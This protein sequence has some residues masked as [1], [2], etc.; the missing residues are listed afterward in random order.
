MVPLKIYTSKDS[1]MH[2]STVCSTINRNQW[3]TPAL[4]QVE[5]RWFICILY[6]H[7]S[8]HCTPWVISHVLWV[9]WIIWWFRKANPVIIPTWNQPIPDVGIIV[10]VKLVAAIIPSVRSFMSVKVLIKAGFPQSNLQE[11]DDSAITGFQ[12]AWSSQS[13]NMANDGNSHKDYSHTQQTR[14]GC[15]HGLVRVTR[16]PLN[17]DADWDPGEGFQ[18]TQ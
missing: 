7:S 3:D 15:L 18:W 14:P 13:Y 11:V 10:W 17:S 6:I 8:I 2:H 5:H 9:W 4:Y 12:P 1:W 16:N